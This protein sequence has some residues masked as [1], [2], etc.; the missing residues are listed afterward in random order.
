[1]FERAAST[2][3]G[4]GFSVARTYREDID[5]LRAIAVLSVIA[6]HWEIAP[7]RGGFVGVDIFLS[8]RD[9]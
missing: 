2:V 3:G 6:F 9:F 7:F 8:S 1:L 5:W 4:R